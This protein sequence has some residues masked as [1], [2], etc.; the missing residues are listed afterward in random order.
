M[1]DSC[2]Y[3]AVI[4]LSDNWKLW[5]VPEFI[6]SGEWG[7]LFLFEPQLHWLS[8][9]LLQLCWCASELIDGTHFHLRQLNNSQFG[10]KVCLMMFR[11][12]PRMTSFCESNRRFA[13]LV[14]ACCKSAAYG[15]VSW[16][17][18]QSME[19]NSNFHSRGMCTSYTPG[20][21][22]VLS[23][24]GCQCWHQYLLIDNLMKFCR[25]GFWLPVCKR[26]MRK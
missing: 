8:A 20:S 17:N 5:R 22:C 13:C 19:R 10:T 1:T 4:G 21:C 9:S 25:W 12:G 2:A 15:A 3:D 7:S 26:K 18:Q 23:L 24:T 6:C 11:L 14:T 16:M